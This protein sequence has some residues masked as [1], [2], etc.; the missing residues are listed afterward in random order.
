MGNIDVQNGNLTSETINFL[1]YYQRK[2]CIDISELKV[3]IR[4]QSSINN[5]NQS[6]NSSSRKETSRQ[7]ENNLLS[8]SDRGK[9][10]S[11]AKKL[12]ELEFSQNLKGWEFLISGERK[13]EKRYYPIEVEYYIY[14]QYPEYRLVSDY[15]N[16]HV[17]DDKD[18][19]NKN[20][21]DYKVYD[22]NGKLIYVPGLKRKEY[23]VMASMECAI[24]ER[25]V[26]RRD[27]DANKYNIMSEPID[28]QRY[29]AHKLGKIK[30]NRFVP[31]NSQE[32]ELYLAQ[33]KSDH[34]SEFGYLYIIERIN[35]TRFRLVFLDK[36]SLKPSICAIVTYTS[37]STPFTSAIS[38]ELTGVPDNIPP[39]IKN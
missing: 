11:D 25:L 21:L 6:R 14:S 9:I 24:I 15:K 1:V 8:P 18:Y 39:A 34:E 17:N 4:Q 35:K 19:V 23:G 2:L 20:I 31:W 26:Y 33:L 36:N 16:D 37:G 27:F 7:S 10:Y 5:Q 13:K 12:N 28:V 32:G 38:I 30:R 29:V 22:K 3:T